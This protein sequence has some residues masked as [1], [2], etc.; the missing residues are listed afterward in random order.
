MPAGVKTHASV[1][2]KGGAKSKLVAQGLV[3]HET[4]DDA[5]EAVETSGPE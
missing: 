5:D 4:D 3:D 2:P 1:K